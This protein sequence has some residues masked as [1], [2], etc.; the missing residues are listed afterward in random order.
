MSKLIETVLHTYDYNTNNATDC[1]PWYQLKTRLEKE[2]ARGHRMH[3]IKPPGEHEQEAGKIVL[4]AEHLFQ[5]QWNSDKG[6]VFDWYEEA[7]FNSRGQP[8]NNIKRGHWLEITPAMIA[9]RR[10][11]LKCGYTGQQFCRFDFPENSFRLNVTDQCLG[12]PYLKETELHLCRLLPVCEEWTTK[13]EELTEAEREY[14][15]PLYIKAQTRT[16][17]AARDKQ[18]AKVLKDFA[19]AT[20][21]ATA[22]RDGYLWLLDHGVQTENCIF[23]SHTGRF[24]F[25]WRSPYTG[26]AREALLAAVAKFPFP[27]DVK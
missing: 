23:Y 16:N 24:A 18:R 17:T 25:G 5:N 20:A 26:K 9:V 3:S 4:E 2:P 15:L 8:M 11:T 10:D 12:S 7:L 6:R 19:A 21:T 14:L 22:E 1:E 27:Y 13:R